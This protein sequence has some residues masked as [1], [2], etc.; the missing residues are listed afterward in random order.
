[1]TPEIRKKTDDLVSLY[2]ELFKKFREDMYV[3]LGVNKTG[4]IINVAILREVIERYYGDL[5]KDRLENRYALFNGYRQAAFTLKWF[6]RLRPIQTSTSLTAFIHANEDFALLL[7]L[8]YLGRHPTNIAPFFHQ[9]FRDVLR[10]D[11][12]D[13]GLLM[14][15]CVQLN[16]SLQ[17]TSVTP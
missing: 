7:A 4:L 2:T 17:T 14:S 12:L 3:T 9:F 11:S 6:M 10:Y 15:V 5:E 1:M 8:T 13:E 16:P